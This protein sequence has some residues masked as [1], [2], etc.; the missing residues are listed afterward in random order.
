MCGILLARKEVIIII[1]PNLDNNN[2]FLIITIDVDSQ[3]TNVQDQLF[4]LIFPNIT[5]LWICICH[6]A[7]LQ[8]SSKFECKTILID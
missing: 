3:R 1:W 4:A 8:L 5:K 7:G 2:H 6:V